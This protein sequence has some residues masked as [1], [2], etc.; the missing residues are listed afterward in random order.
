MSKGKLV[1]VLGCGTLFFLGVIF[2]AWSLMSAGEDVKEAVKN[3]PEPIPGSVTEERT[4]HTDDETRTA[5]TAGSLTV[6][7]ARDG[8]QLIEHAGLGLAVRIPATWTID[9]DTRNAAL[10]TIYENDTGSV[11][12]S[13]EVFTENALSG[14]TPDGWVRENM[15]VSTTEPS[16]VSGYPGV[17][18]I[19]DSTVEY[20][21]SSGVLIEGSVQ[22]HQVVIKEGTV[23]HAVCDARGATLSEQ[24][25][26][27]E[28][29]IGSL[30]F[31]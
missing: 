15:S 1:F 18:F 8:M 12:A 20:M 24:A 26:I 28:K 2:A 7:E 5:E 22:M 19:V 10:R 31:F 4:P 30:A 23:V 13:L 9:R 16:Y 21:G 14:V 25:V 17:R 27:C 6:Y 29:V 11:D 3:R